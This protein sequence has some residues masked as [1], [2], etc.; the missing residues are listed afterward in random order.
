MGVGGQGAFS[1]SN[2]ARQRLRQE[3]KME[4]EGLFYHSRQPVPASACTEIFIHLPVSHLRLLREEVD[5][6]R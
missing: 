3:E 4:L 6:G 2:S 1:I 5:E